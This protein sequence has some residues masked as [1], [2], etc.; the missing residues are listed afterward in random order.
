MNDHGVL[1][2]ALMRADTEDRVVELLTKAG[3]WDDPT[4]WRDLG[5]DDTNFATIGNQQSEGVAA[6]IEKVVNGIDARLMSA[7]SASG[8]DPESPAAPTSIRGA[9][10]RYFEG[11][12]DAGERDG[13]IA[14]WSDVKA[15]DEAKLLTLS[16]T[17]N[18]PDD[19]LPS[20]TVADQGEGQEPDHFPETF[21]SLHR[22]NKDRV[23]FVQGKFNMGGTGALQFCRGEH[24]LQLI[25]SRRNPALV[26]PGS[27]DRAQQWGFTVI[28]REP[29]RP[30]RRSSVFTYLAPVGATSTKRGNV[31]SFSA[32]SWPIFP[33]AD[34]KV[35]DAYHR[36]AE[37]GSL[38][39]LYEYEWGSTTSN[40]VR[41]GGGLLQRLDVG[42]PELALPVRVFECRSGYSGHAGSFATNLMGLSARL[43]KD[44]NQNLEPERPSG[45]VINLDGCPVKL[46]IF[47]FKAGKGRDYRSARQGV[48]FS[49]NGQSHATFSTDFFRRKSVGMAYL[50]DSL[51]VLADCSA[52]DGQM[53]EDLFMNSRD[54]L[55]D[56]PL[57]RR[58]EKELEVL[59][60]DDATLKELR[61]RRRSEEL[62]EKLAD[63]KPLV[64]VLQEILKSSPTLAKLFMLGVKLPSPFPPSAG[65]KKGTAGEFHGKT[66]PTYFRFKGLDDHEILTRDVHLGSRARITMETD[67]EDDYFLRDLDPG[68]S[69][70]LCVTDEGETE[71]DDWVMGG[72]K[73]GLVAFSLL[74]LPQDSRIDDVLTYRIEVT[75]PSRIDAFVNSLELTVCPE[76]IASGRHPYGKSQHRN[77]GSGTG[78]GSTM[79]QLPNIREVT[80]DEWTKRG[81][82]ELT[83]L[84]IVGAGTQSDGT[85]LFDFFV[86]V[87]NKFLRLFQKESREDPKLIKAKF[88]YGLVLVGLALLQD[89][90]GS[91]KDLGKEV[92]GSVGGGIEKLVERV[93]G[94][95]APILLP[96]LE[97]IGALEVSDSE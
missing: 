57:A 69:R 76:A 72:L 65:S 39:K 32:P 71:V 81:F 54:R 51:L 64:D 61:N 23:H 84:R 53:R 50:A 37:Y 58:L 42:L 26:K 73:S 31:L 68:A 2:S 79:L 35:R 47:V 20:L 12:K 59:L 4:A 80:Q 8:V 85:E 41:S 86:N 25:V 19:G 13:R 45:K 3:Y 96:L 46:R 15:T 91:D 18:M 74:E 78:G 14:E 60:R 93:T 6:L 43:Q 48:V 70:L 36:H 28:R 77:S 97:S 67:A 22:S 82:T 94:A 44:K 29:P 83:A 90:N 87:D 7:C 34:G 89:R 11:T 38:I 16:A 27:S 95:V 88:V 33:E 30:G 49:V 66:Y 55:R 5:D 92:G 52:I 1:C 40:I 9:V 63:S 75:D 10:A 56:T 62:S 17:G 21:L 24:K